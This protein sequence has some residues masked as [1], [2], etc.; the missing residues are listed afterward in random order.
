MMPR[1]RFIFFK[2]IDNFENLISVLYKYS[3]YVFTGDK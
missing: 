1:K 3:R 2:V